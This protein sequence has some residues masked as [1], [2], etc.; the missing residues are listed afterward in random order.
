MWEM[1]ADGV[2]WYPIVVSGFRLTLGQLVK[3]GDWWVRNVRQP[4]R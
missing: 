2:K 3:R 1:S 4:E